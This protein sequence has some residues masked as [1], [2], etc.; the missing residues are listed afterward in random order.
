MNSLLKIL[1]SLALVLSAST[2]FATGGDLVN[3]GGGLSEK[4]ILFAYEK[5]NKFIQLCLNSQACKLTAPQK[6]IL[7]KIYAGLDKEK[8]IAQLE[9]ASEKNIPGY[10]MIDGQVRVARTGSAIGSIIRINSD[11]LY[12]KNEMGVYEPISIADGLAILIHEL[13]HHYGNYT[14]EEL[15][16][17]GV[18]VSMLLQQ[19][20]ISTPMIPWTPEISAQVF[21]PDLSSFPDVLLTVGSQVI[22]ISRQYAKTVR[23]TVFK[24]PIPVLPIP[25]IELVTETP[26]GSIL[27]NVHWD[28]VKDSD[29]SIK[30]R[31]VGNV[32]NKCAQRQGSVRL[33]NSKLSISFTIQKKNGRYIYLPQTLVVDQFKDPWWKFIKLPI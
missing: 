14:H 29:D 18:R 16:L 7:K 17:L 11:L 25:D 1:F 33:N 3:N 27:H 5:L 9:F 20:I 22:D 21:N 24:V 32:S 2:S 13:G 28:G 30:V 4:N 10:F 15:D 26:V 19:K 6:D 23:C 12:T 8:A 31:I